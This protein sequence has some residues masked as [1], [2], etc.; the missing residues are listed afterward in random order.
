MQFQLLMHKP[1]RGF[2]RTRSGV[3]SEAAAL[4]EW[5][6]SMTPPLTLPSLA[7]LLSTANATRHTCCCPDSG[8]CSW[9]MLLRLLHERLRSLLYR[10]IKV[11]ECVSLRELQL[12]WKEGWPWSVF[13]SSCFLLFTTYFPLSENTTLRKQL[14]ALW[15]FV[16]RPQEKTVTFLLNQRMRLCHITV[17]K[18][19]FD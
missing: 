16:R 15:I 6:V 7:H 8:R 9:K 11:S 12:F 19:Q 10:H 17:W 14:M 13:V 18:D 3:S 5:S 2:L 1:G 4:S